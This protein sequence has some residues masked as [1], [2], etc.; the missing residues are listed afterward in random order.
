MY[1]SSEKT[2]DIKV[3]FKKKEGKEERD[4]RNLRDVNNR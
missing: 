3:N 2:R 4:A 1:H